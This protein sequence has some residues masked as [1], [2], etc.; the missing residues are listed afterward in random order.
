MEILVNETFLTALLIIA[1]LLT[2]VQVIVT[3]F[4]VKCILKRIKE[5]DRDA[6]GETMGGESIRGD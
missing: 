2:I 6:K 4:T 1:A 5:A 3:I